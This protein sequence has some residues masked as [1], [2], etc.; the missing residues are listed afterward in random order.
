[1]NLFRNTGDFL[2][3]YGAVLATY[4]RARPLTTITL[5]LCAV[6]SRITRML[7]RLLPLKVILLAGSEGVPSYFAPFLAPDQK[8]IGLIILTVAAILCYGADFFL[9][10]ITMKLSESGSRHVA[11]GANEIVLADQLRQAQSGY[12]RVMELTANLVFACVGF[13]V[14]A[15]ADLWLV[16]FLLGFFAAIYLFTAWALRGNVY[17]QHRPLAHFIRTNLKS[18]LETLSIIS[19]IVAF[20]FIV[21][22]FVTGSPANVL[23]AMIAITFLR[24]TLGS[25][26]SAA[27]SATSLI[28]R[29]HEVNAL[30]F[31]NHHVQRPEKADQ[32]TLRETFSGE[33][34]LKAI[35]ADLRS[36]DQ[37]LR[38]VSSTWRDK[39]GGV[40]AF[41]V[42]AQMANGAQ[43]AFMARIFPEDQLKKLDNEEFL[44]ANVSAQALQTPK[45]LGRLE[46]LPFT[47]NLWEVGPHARELTKEEWR[48]AQPTLI[49]QF[50]SYVPPR[51]L[52]TA[53]RLSHSLLHERVTDALIQRVSLAIDGA[54]ATEIFK[55]FNANFQSYRERIARVPLFIWNTSLA[56]AILM[57]DQGRYLMLDWTAWR[58]EPIGVGHMPFRPDQ[59][60]EVLAK[61]SQARSDW[62]AEIDAQDV[63]LARQFWILESLINGAQYRSAYGQIEAI[64]TGV[65]AQLVAGGSS[66]DNASETNAEEDE[67]ELV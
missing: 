18:Y 11:K 5:L 41:S 66:E 2:K 25:V 38:D 58:L 10:S 34:R 45:N 39:I 48:L 40:Q 31:R 32:R 27:K 33:G 16:A 20:L 46:Q 62:P 13:G 60:P 9:D 28:S 61:V 56:P 12:S 8:V 21:A 53:Y 59:L 65:S 22:P 6:G 43:K 52:V 42:R 55:T 35:S 29:V 23:V 24:R 19:F 37:S 7:S 4:L 44:L 1:M 15:T 36:K 50:W 30:I 26:T 3:W 14:I 63:F 57:V 54:A 51:E 67:D 17:A 64:V 49:E 47:L